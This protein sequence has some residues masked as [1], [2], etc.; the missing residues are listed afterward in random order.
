MALCR[1]CA[2]NGI[3]EWLDFGPQP[4]A[5][6]FLRSPDEVEYVH[7][8]KVG[9]CRACGTVQLESPV[10]VGEM[11]PRFDWLTY[12]EPERHLDDV[13]DVLAA[14][15]G[16]TPNSAVG[17]VTY[18]DDSTL[19][20]LAARGFRNI[21]RADPMADL[22]VDSPLGGIESIQD[23]FP[24]A[25][26]QLVSRYGQADLLLVRHI[27]EHAADVHGFLRGVRAAVRPGG[28]ALF[29]LPDCRKA[30]DRLDYTTVWEE[31]LLYFTPA[32]LRHLL[33]AAGFEVVSLE[34]FYYTQD[35]VLVCVAKPAAAR[36]GLPDAPR[37]LADELARAD[38][39]VR[40]FPQTRH[41][42]RQKVRSLTSGG[43][44]FAMLGA[45][46]L[47]GAFIN[48][49]GLATDTTLVA[50]DNPKK[51]GLY[52]PGSKAPILPAAEL[53]ARNVQLCLMTVR[54]EVEE[55]VVGKNAAYLARGGVLASVFPDSKYAL[56]RAGPAAGKAA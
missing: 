49:Y 39:F 31:H 55:L 6:R 46:H 27:L 11:R 10:P 18:K 2:R 20:R 17:G 13:A 45:G 14:L 19:K 34:S 15:P 16:L 29:E 30:F 36:D 51:H 8:C 48:L 53:S 40:E 5:N 21:W 22:G 24:H 44:A 4:L 32:T 33:A 47:S 7:P 9:I 52:M 28:Y 54:A 56:G 3:R 12:N 37:E 35:N 42:V 25:A 26:G 50:D 38:R 41:D 1:I 43:G 23:R